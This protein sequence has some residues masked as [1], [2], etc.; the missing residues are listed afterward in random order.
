[1]AEQD[2]SRAPSSRRNGPL[3]SYVRELIRD[4]GWSAARASQRRARQSGNGVRRIAGAAIGVQPGAGPGAQ[5][6]G[7]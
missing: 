2:T 4:A 3:D 6:R 5:S 7:A 1:M